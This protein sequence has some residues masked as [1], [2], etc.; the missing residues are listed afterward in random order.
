LRR[1]STTRSVDMTGRTPRPVMDVPPGW[2][3]GPF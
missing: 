3:D 1:M 2:V